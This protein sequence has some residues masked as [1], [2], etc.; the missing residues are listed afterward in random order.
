MTDSPIVSSDPYLI[1]AI[2]MLDGAIAPLNVAMA[3][4]GWKTNRF[5]IHARLKAGTLPVRAEKLGRNWYVTAGAVADLL[6]SSTSPSLPP[7][8]PQP[9]TASPHRKPGRP[10]G[11]TRRA[12]K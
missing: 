9:P 11:T 7:S 12:G 1:E 5:A 2:R 8:Q 6:R 10:R 3:K 4:I